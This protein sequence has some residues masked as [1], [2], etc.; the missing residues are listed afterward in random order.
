M[1]GANEQYGNIY[2]PVCKCEALA[3]LDGAS[4]NRER[5]SRGTV[6]VV[7]SRAELASKW[8]RHGARANGQCR[9]VIPAAAEA[10][11]DFLSGPDPANNRVLNILN[12]D[13][14]D[15]SDHGGLLVVVVH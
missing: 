10:D 1:P 3:V 2:L 4:S 12:V 8:L 5:E 9:D 13:N 14:L 6:V 15:A 7:V 11:G